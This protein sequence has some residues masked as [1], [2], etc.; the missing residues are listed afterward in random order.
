MNITLSE[1]KGSLFQISSYVR[2]WFITLSIAFFIPFMLLGFALGVS[3]IM[4]ASIQD[5]WEIAVIIATTGSLSD[6]QTSGAWNLVKTLFGGVAFLVIFYRAVNSQMLKSMDRSM[7]LW[8]KGSS[9]RQ[10]LMVVLGIFMT[11]LLF[12]GLT[13]NIAEHKSINSLNN[14]DILADSV[15]VPQSS[16]AIV[17]GDTIQSGSAEVIQL[18]NG[19]F[20]V[21]FKE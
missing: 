15:P 14:L 16:A 20:N 19:S 11:S 12:Y 10:A 2:W 13:T 3:F 1:V 9:K 4:G 7:T 8:I 17:L 5:Y 21:R 6:W 18:K